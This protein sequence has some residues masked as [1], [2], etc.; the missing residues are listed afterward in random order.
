MKRLLRQGWV[1]LGI[2]SCSIESLADHSWSVAVLTYICCI[3]EN[4]YR[5]ESKLQKLDL[6]KSVLIALFHDFPESEYLDIDKSVEEI[7]ENEKIK[8]IRHNLEN[9]AINSILAKFPAK[10]SNFIEEILQDH[11]SDEY[12][13][14][15]IA[16][17]L[18]LLLQ[19]NNYSNKSWL[20]KLE[21]KKFQNH[22]INLIMQY[23][24]Q[25]KF[26]IPYLKES[27]LI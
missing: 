27:G 23:S 24:K 25:F 16:D 14:V 11:K 13:L 7:L 10:I 1:R 20:N 5:D 3:Q 2:P 22:A 21:T 19:T 9:G 26:L 17:L 6:E 18:D 8:E 15:R 12:H 4:I